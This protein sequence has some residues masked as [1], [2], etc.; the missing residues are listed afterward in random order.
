[1]TTVPLG[2]AAAT[3]QLRAV[4]TPR[5]RFLDRP[6]TSYYLVAGSAGLLVVLGLVMVLS[7]SSVSSFQASGNSYALFE[8]QLMWVVIGAPFAVAAARLPLSYIRRTGHPLVLA[9]VVGLLAVL[10]PGI[11]I[12]AYGA[13]RWVGVGGFTVQP[14]EIA[15]LAL[16]LWGADVLVRKWKLLDEWKHILVPLLP[17]GL[18]Y[19]A[20]VMA[21]PDMG[22]TIVLL[23]IVFTLL[24]VV[25]AP[26]R[27][28]AIALGSI[29]SVGALLAI[30]EP[31]RLARLTSFLHPFHDSQ[32]GGYQAVQGIYALAAGGWWGKGLGSSAEKWGYLPNAHTD[33]I[34]AIIGEELGLLGT[35]LVI[36]L[37]G[38][39]GYAGFRV[40]QR[41]TERY[42]R[43][44]AAAIT[45]WIVGQAV[46]NMGAV[47]GV[48]P[49]TGI[50]LPLIS[51]GGSALVPE[52]I[53]IGLLASFARTEKGVPARR[54]RR[55]ARH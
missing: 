51:F 26:G 53:A 40:A 33:F 6:M 27:I 44:A 30:A 39:L 1:M 28:F 54:S 16:V 32:Q 25:G 3:R 17:V 49:I 45:V 21:E 10:V 23:L 34:F 14:S 18:L 19:A 46:V 29:A 48:L 52:M 9:T 55:R 22:T 11:G 38:V 47:V 2:R 41:T 15:K 20:L 12:S 24:W 8:K 50:P 4:A 43:L 5:P 42:V 36:G 37:F 31:Y 35:L 13:T 7:A